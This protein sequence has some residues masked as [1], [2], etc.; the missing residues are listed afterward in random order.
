[1][2]TYQTAPLYAPVFPTQVHNPY[3]VQPLKGNTLA[4]ADLPSAGEAY[5][6]SWKKEADLAVM[7]RLENN[8]LKE[9]DML[10][11]P[12][13]Q[14]GNFTFTTGRGPQGHAFEGQ[15]L[16][17]GTVWT[18]E[19][20][21]TI[22]KLLRDRKFQLDAIDQASFDTVSPERVKQPD[23]PADTF[24]VDQTFGN[25]LSS[26]DEGL[27]TPSL[28][29]Y[30][31]QIMNFFLTKADKIPDHKFA[32]YESF[33]TNLAEL[34][35]G[36]FYSAAEA[37]NEDLQIK[38]KRILKKLEKDIG[39]MSDFIH[40]FMDYLGQPTKT[41]SMRLAGIRNKLLSLISESA[42]KAIKDAREIQ[43]RYERGSIIG[44]GGP[45][46]RSSG[47]TLSEFS[48][49]SGN[50]GDSGDSGDGSQTPS[51]FSGTPANS[52]A[53]ARVGRPGGAPVFNEQQP[54]LEAY[55]FGPRGEGLFGR[56]Y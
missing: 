21:T 13:S 26:L 28:L 20:E 2:P 42:Q 29:G 27:I 38:Q 10:K 36:A 51:E 56:R 54:G 35:D 48:G 8:H 11:G 6:P 32:E 25:L 5:H 52:Y 34:L 53:S 7:A 4:Y 37:G 19:G 1:M 23:V 41:K 43:G 55:G 24:T 17:G 14:K 15:K 46:S 18:T 44:P 39:G 30:T 16:S 3:G 33:L 50:S 12:S 49:D 22:Q 9:K 31:S 40:D 47:T 45:T